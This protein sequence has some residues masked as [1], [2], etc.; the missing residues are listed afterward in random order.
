MLRNRTRP[1]QILLC[2]SLAVSGFAVLCPFLLPGHFD[3]LL[4]YLLYSLPLGF[5]AGMFAFWAR[6]LAGMLIATFAAFAP[7]LIIWGLLSINISPFG[8]LF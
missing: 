8:R 1:A 2:I 7:L 3:G 6:S 4:G 5:L